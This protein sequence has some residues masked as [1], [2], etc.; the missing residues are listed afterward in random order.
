MKNLTLL[1]IFLLEV[2]I[3]YGRNNAKLF[4]LEVARFSSLQ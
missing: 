4:F 1:F 2:I 3:A